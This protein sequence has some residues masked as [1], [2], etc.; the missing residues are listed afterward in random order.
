MSGN[1]NTLADALQ[2]GEHPAIYDVKSGAT[3]SAA[4]LRRL[5][6]STAATLRQSGVQP[7][8]TVSIVD[9]NTVRCTASLAP[10]MQAAV[11]CAELC[12]LAR[13]ETQVLLRS[14]APERGAGLQLEFVVVFLGVTLARATAAPL[15][16]G[17][18]QVRCCLLALSVVL[19]CPK[20]AVSC[21]THS[22]WVC[23]A[24]PVTAAG[25]QDEFKFY[26]EDAKSALV[27]VP[28][29]G[30]AKAEAAAA[31]FRV[32]VASLAVHLSSGAS[33][34]QPSSV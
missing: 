20:S 18:S 28:A 12:L 3:V 2:Q 19:V 15:N 29:K 6:L 7:G 34:C 30:N 5:V 22:T 9:A 14:A 24:S 25:V 4:A 8:Q 31:A 17:Y 33:M 1:T 16:A 27:L 10:Q 26:F 21:L 11:S 23:S 32:P 13:W